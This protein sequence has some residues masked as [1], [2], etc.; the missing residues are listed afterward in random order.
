MDGLAN[1]MVVFGAIYFMK[2]IDMQDEENIFKLRILYYS[3]QSLILLIN[4]YIYSLIKSKNNQKQIYD[5]IA[6]TVS[7]PN[8]QGKRKISIAQYDSEKWSEQVKQIVTT[9][10][11]V[12]FIHFKM[13]AAAPLFIQ[14]FLNPMNL[15][16]KNKLFSAYIMGNDL[17]RPFP[18]PPNPFAALLGGGGDDNANEGSGNNTNNNNQDDS[19]SDS[20]SEEEKKEK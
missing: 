9:T 15:L 3:V 19:D 7:E 14:S 12:S 5:V 2:Q 17:D 18:K 11:I 10:L 20:D 1:M 4:F 13:E 8:P 16:T 6:P